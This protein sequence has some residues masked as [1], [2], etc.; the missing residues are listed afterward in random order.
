MYACIPEIGGGFFEAVCAPSNATAIFRDPSPPYSTKTGGPL[1]GLRPKEG[2]A[3]LY[4]GERF[5]LG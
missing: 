5:V 1:L 4:R 2:H 3:P